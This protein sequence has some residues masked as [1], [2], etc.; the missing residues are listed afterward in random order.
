MLWECQNSDRNKSNTLSNL[1][2]DPK[3]IILDPDPQIENQEFRIL[4]STI[5]GEKKFSIL[6]NNRTQMGWNLELID[7][8]STRIVYEIMMNLF[9]L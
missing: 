1:V 6:V 5:D 8:S 9:T 3:L 7:F 4:L 2:P